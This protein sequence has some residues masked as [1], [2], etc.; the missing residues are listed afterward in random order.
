[1]KKLL[2]MLTNW[3]F[4]EYLFFLMYNAAWQ[5]I[6][7]AWKVRITKFWYVAGTMNRNTEII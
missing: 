5:L 7:S 3:F 4:Q 2:C 6:D 1:M